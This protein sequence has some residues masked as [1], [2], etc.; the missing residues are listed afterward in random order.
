MGK[1][2]NSNRF[3]FLGL[4]NH[5]RWWL[6]PW[7]S[8]ML[9]PWEKSSDQPRHHIKKQRHH[10]A[11]KGLYSQRYVFFSSYVW[12]PELDHKEGWALRNWF[13]RTV[14]LQKTLESPLDCREIKPK[15]INPEYSLERLRLRL[16]L[17]YFGYLMWRA[18]SLEKTLMVGKTEGRRRRGNR[19]W[20]G[21]MASPTPWTWVWANLHY[22]GVGVGQGSLASCT[23]WGPQRVRHI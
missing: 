5:C 2:G 10:F 22:P 3:Y 13:F 12:M 14:V 4:Q 18:D 9:A 17:Q 15:E 6:Q 16:N 19:R 1:N 8:K 20:D 21:W 7:N 11:N 23:A